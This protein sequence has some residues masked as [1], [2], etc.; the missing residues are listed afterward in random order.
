METYKQ[1]V[2]EQSRELIW[3]HAVCSLTSNR[4]S[5]R[6]LTDDYIKNLWDYIFG[7]SKYTNRFFKNKPLPDIG[8]LNSW[9]S[10]AHNIY[11]CKEPSDL[12]IAYLCGPEPENDLNILLRLG[13]RIENIWAIE[14]DKNTFITALENVKLQ[15]PTLKIFHGSIDDFFG[16]YKLQFDIIYLD[17]TAPIFSKEAKPFLTIHK[18]FDDQVLSEL[19]ILI[20]NYSVP[21]KNDDSVELLTK[22]FVDHEY[23]ESSIYGYRD[24]NG[25]LQYHF[26][27]GVGAHY[28]E[29][30]VKELS[31]KIYENFE[32]AYSAFCSLY[33]VFYANIISPEFRVVKENVLRRKLFNDSDEV[34]QKYINKKYENDYSCYQSYP[35]VGFV[36][37]LSSSK[38]KLC[39]YWNNVYSSKEAGTKFSRTNSVKLAGIIK[40]ALV[41]EHISLL[42]DSLFKSVKNTYAVMKEYEESRIFCDILFPNV[43]IEIALNQFGIPYHSNFFNHKRY[44]YTAKVREMFIDIFTFDKCRAFYD[45]IPLIEFYDVN[46]ALAERQMILRSC[47]DVIGGKQLGFT[48]IPLYNS[49]VN[50]IGMFEEKWAKFADG[51]PKRET[52]E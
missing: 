24:E 17:F 36:D 7:K 44:R 35:E 25:E 22:F 38:T 49:G 10:F 12:R 1:D 3:Q 20:T 46:L 26:G 52:I 30:N 2:K 45:W 18:I 48:P 27:D 51:F 15:Y 9:H 43:L 14:S 50:V 6:I 40:D 5:T 41:E 28:G 29:G 39:Q 33:P 16:V 19:G 13:L 34:I 47:I 42:S 31:K 4:N 21:D 37:R 23:M 11:G 32:Y 8:F